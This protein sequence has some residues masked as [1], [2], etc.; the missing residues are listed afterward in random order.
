MSRI[1]RSSNT[2]QQ[3]EKQVEI[4]LRNLFKVDFDGE[5]NDQDTTTTMDE[6]YAKRDQILS[7]AAS[8][9]ESQRQEFE[10]YRQ[11]Q[12]EMLEQLKKMWEEEKLV[13][14]QNAYEQGFQQGYEEGL[15]KAHG[16]MAES[17]SVANKVIEDSRSMAQNYI[18]EQEQVILELALTASERII[19]ASLE[20]DDEVFL[21]IV[22]RGLKEAREMKEIKIYVSPTYHHLITQHR[23]ELVEMFP[24]DVPLLVF[25]DE[26]LK[27]TECFIE[28]NHGRIVV[29]I[30]E[31]LSELRLKLS[32]ILDS[33]E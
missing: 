32:E 7:A 33:K 30:D 25:V 12:L 18:E 31:Q 20:R 10:Q 5:E 29:S 4:Q 1:I 15:K 8:E 19:G 26:D 23:S 22:K 11:E 6:I 9:I 27:Q 17:L 16:D 14:E 2:V 3:N 24:T 28:T 21:S 13:L